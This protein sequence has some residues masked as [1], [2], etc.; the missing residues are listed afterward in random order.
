M[1]KIVELQLTSEQEVC[2]ARAAETHTANPRVSRLLVQYTQQS[3]LLHHRPSKT[4]ATA[5]GSPVFPNPGCATTL[6]S[7][8]GPDLA[9]IKKTRETEVSIRVISIELVI[10]ILL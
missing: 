2:T 5:V 9:L 10:M 7:T 1:I 6:R 8:H 4:T 3:L